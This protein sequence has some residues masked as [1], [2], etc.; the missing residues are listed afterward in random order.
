MIDR[1]RTHDA[2]SLAASVAHPHVRVTVKTAL[3]EPREVDPGRFPWSC[4]SRSFPKG[5]VISTSARTDNY[6]DSKTSARYFWRFPTGN[7]VMIRARGTMRAAVTEQGAFRRFVR[8]RQM[9]ER[10]ANASPGDHKRE[11]TA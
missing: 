5:P 7:R 9:T 10:P 2:A 8:E 11:Q 4:C 1:C 6:D 3:G